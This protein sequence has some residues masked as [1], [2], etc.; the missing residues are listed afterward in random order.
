MILEDQCISAERTRQS[1]NEAV[2]RT[3]KE[4]FSWIDPY[5]SGDRFKMEKDALPF[6]SVVISTLN[7]Q[8][9]LE[10]GSGLSTYV[11]VQAAQRLNFNC[12]IS[13]IDHDP[14][15]GAQ[16]AAKY[17]GNERKQTNCQV[18]MQ[19]APLVA[20]KY[21]GEFLPSYLIDPERLASPQKV[22]LVII[23]GPPNI[24][25]G[26]E[27]TLYQMLEFSKP[28]TLMLL[29]DSG[30]SEERIA[31]SHWKQNLG[32]AIEIIKL[33]GFS[34]GMVAVII[35]EP[36]C[37]S[38]LLAHKLRLFMDKI[39]NYIP[40][41][42]TV[43]VIG[44]DWYSNEINS[45]YKA[46]SYTESQGQYRGLPPDDSFAIEEL[47]RMRSVGATLLV[48]SLSS[49]WWLEHYKEWHNYLQSNYKCTLEND[50]IVVFGLRNDTRI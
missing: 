38:N 12:F 6:I 34:R 36:I 11:I 41:K 5:I 47:E 17:Y 37:K 48:I 25:G 2:I 23:D 29:D 28:G 33:Q 1:L 14:I 32:E 49:F 18:S 42:D 3:S 10:F 9:I 20:R 43:I 26:R 27:G 21:G 8:H 24:L 22:D 39:K 40:L 16:A 7:P 30:R 31:I 13:S 35:R 45:H 4:D 44:D 46:L 15:F 19:I 50:R